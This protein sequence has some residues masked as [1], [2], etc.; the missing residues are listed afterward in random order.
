[1]RRCWHRVLEGEGLGRGEGDRG[2]SEGRQKP[3]W[4]RPTLIYYSYYFFVS[5]VCLFIYFVCFALPFFPSP[6]L[7]LAGAPMR[8]SPRPRS[9]CAPPQCNKARRAG[10]SLP[11]DFLPAPPLLP[12]LFFCFFSCCCCC[13]FSF[14][15]SSSPSAPKAPG[16]PR[17]L[18]APAPAPRPPRR[19]GL[20]G[21]CFLFFLS[22]FFFFFL[23]FLL[24]LLLPPLSR[25]LSLARFLSLPA[26]F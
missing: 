1:M 13:F 12:T 3:T 7:L 23:L 20:G 14:F 2:R 17:G 4:E 22:S 25:S 18:R 8:R 26:I 15:C 6:L 16:R 21:I 24:P 10:H 19:T 11:I 9:L 5:F